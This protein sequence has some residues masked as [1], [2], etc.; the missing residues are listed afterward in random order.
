MIRDITERL[1]VD[2]DFADPSTVD[3]AVTRI[4][5]GGNAIVDSDETATKVLIEL[6][7]TAARAAFQVRG[8]HGIPR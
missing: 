4:R 1:R 2:T 5:A 3:V 7:V 8:S 6:G